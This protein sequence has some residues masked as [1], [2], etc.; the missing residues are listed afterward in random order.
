MASTH[1]IQALRAEF[2]PDA[3]AIELREP[4]LS[5]R[6]TLYALLVLVLAAVL[7][8]TFSDIDK[9]VIARG[10]LVTP[11]PNLVVQPLEPG[12]LKGINVRVGQVVEKGAVL[13]TLDPTFAAADAS[14]LGSRS[15]ILSLQARRLESELQGKSQL[16]GGTNH[17]QRQLQTSLQAERQAAF[18]ARIQQFAETIQRLRAML[19][20]NRQDQQTLARRLKSLTELEAMHSKLEAEK[21]GSRAKLLEA[22]ERRLEVERDYTQATNREREILR[23]IATVEA[24]R[25]SFSKTWRQDAMEKLSSTLQQRDEVHEQLAKARLRSTLVTLTAPQDAIVLEIGKKSVGSIVKDAEPLFVLVPLDATLEAE[26]EVDPA[27][28][29]EM[30]VKDDTRIKIDAYPF[31]KHGTIRGRVVSV[32]ADTFSRQ[33]AMGGQG[34]YYLARVSLE[35]TRL[36]HVPNP[37]RLLPGMTLTGEIVTGKRSVISYF[38]YPVIRVLDESLR[39]R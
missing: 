23:E 29:G 6:L 34:Y 31:Q 30:R 15:D 39:E 3:Q 8:A 9:L 25:T 16:T 21:F 19:E 24:E 7:W 26:V 18:A 14:Q 22:Q 13:A 38:L 4:P 33:N 10:R 37:T 11:L 12:I 32:S 35:D 5:R 36:E 2:L 20:S 1:H 28:V 27:D 17:P